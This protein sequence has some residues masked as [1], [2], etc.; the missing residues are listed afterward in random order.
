MTNMRLMESYA[1]VYQRNREIVMDNFSVLSLNRWCQFTRH[2]DSQ[3][4]SWPMRGSPE[5]Q[6]DTTHQDCAI[7]WYAQLRYN[8]T[9]SDG[10]I[11]SHI[12][13]NPSLLSKHILL[14]NL[15]VV[16]SFLIH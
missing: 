6:H 16:V 9:T 7:R 8:Q 2:E 14:L 5:T 11:K 15:I 10:Q 4:C 12:K 1:N 3:Y 13:S